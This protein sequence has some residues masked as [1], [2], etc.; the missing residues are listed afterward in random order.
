M[1]AQEWTFEQLAQRILLP[2]SV[3]PLVAAKSLL[4]HP[5]SSEAITEDKLTRWGKPSKLELAQASSILGM[6]M[7]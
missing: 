1:L 5:P 3:K 4:L 2:V 6:N 7:S